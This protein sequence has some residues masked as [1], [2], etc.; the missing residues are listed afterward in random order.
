LNNQEY[1]DTLI[2][3]VLSQEAT[4]SEQAELDAWKLLNPENAVYFNKM[5]KLFIKVPEVQHLEQFNTDAAWEKLKKEI[6]SEKP[7][8]K[9]RQLKSENNRYEFIRVAAMILFVAGVAF[10][11]YKITENNTANPVIVSS[12]DSVKELPLPDSS[13]VVL[14]KNSKLTY[15]FSKNKRFVE[16]H[17]EAFFELA[18]DKNRPFEVLAGNV[19]IRDIGTA[20]NV[21]APDG[22]DSLVVYVTDGEVA[23]TS[24]NKESLILK[25]GEEGIYIKTLDKFIKVA[26][27]DTN[28]TAYKTKIFVFENASLEA[29][30]QKL[31]EVYGTQISIADVIKSC[32]L[33][34]T[35]KNENADRIVDIIAETLQLKVSRDNKKIILDGKVCEE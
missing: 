5:H 17:G 24:L 4:T 22:S 2:A 6:N 13:Q 18:A 11:A 3:K 31:N 19:I 29:V 15:A 25:K 27:A 35:F 30:A 20:F 34:A 33:T 9:V 12:S 10:A 26:K 21:K 14:N 8:G 1:I 16:L 7:A 23:L 32:H 28:A